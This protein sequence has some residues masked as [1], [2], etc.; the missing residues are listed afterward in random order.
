M[1][2]AF[3]VGLSLAVTLFAPSPPGALRTGAGSIAALRAARAISHEASLARPAPESVG[4][5]PPQ[6]SALV[7]NTGRST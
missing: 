5:D 2:E 3:L 7:S 4:G 1:R 6:R